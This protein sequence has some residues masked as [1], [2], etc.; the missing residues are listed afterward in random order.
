MSNDL[1]IGGME[2][3]SKSIAAWVPNAKGKTFVIAGMNEPVDC[4]KTFPRLEN[5]MCFGNIQLF[6]K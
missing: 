3:W 4:E 1:R 5:Y 2:D 6:L